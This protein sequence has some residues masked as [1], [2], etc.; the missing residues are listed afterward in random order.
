MKVAVEGQVFNLHYRQLAGS[1]TIE[2][3]LEYHKINADEAI[4][5]YVKLDN[6][7]AYMSFLSYSVESNPIG[8]LVVINYLDNI[9]QTRRW[10]QLVYGD[11]K[12]EL[13]ARVNPIS[14][15][16]DRRLTNDLSHIITQYTEF[17]PNEVLPFK[18]LYTFEDILARI[19]SFGNQEV[20]ADDTDHILKRL[21]SSS[22]GKWYIQFTR[23]KQYEKLTAVDLTRLSDW[24]FIVKARDAVSHVANDRKILYGHHYRIYYD[25]P[26]RVD[27]TLRG[28]AKFISPR[29][30]EYYPDITVYD[31][32]DKDYAYCPKNTPYL[33]L[34]E[35]DTSLSVSCDSQPHEG[36]KTTPIN[37]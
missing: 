22:V 32:P 26:R 2:G 28:S 36:N 24:M 5:I 9:E 15:E 31:L 37:V 14:Q 34:S 20:T 35:H 27:V 23:T 18:L 29:I 8:A 3:L 21:F 25:V 12:R 10:C 19:Q 13:F 17:K 4:P 7:L 1:K 6:W 30:A 16:I 33:A 11:R